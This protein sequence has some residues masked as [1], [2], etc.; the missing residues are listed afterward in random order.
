M[1]SYDRTRTRCVCACA[2]AGVC[3]C[4]RACVRAYFIVNRDERYKGTILFE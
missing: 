1:N 2:R 4:V 3:E